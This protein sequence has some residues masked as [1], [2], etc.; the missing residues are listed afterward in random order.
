MISLRSRRKLKPSDAR[1]F[2]GYG[3]DLFGELAAA[4][5][6][7]GVIPQKELHECWQMGEVVHAEFPESL[8]IADIA[9]GHGLLAWILVLLARVSAAPIPRT[10]IALDVRRPP[11]ANVLSAAM[12]QRWPALEDSVH[13]VEGRVESVISTQ[14]STTLFVAAHACGSLSDRVLLAAIA[15]RNPLAVMPCCLSVRKQADSLST[16][17]AVAGLPSFASS[18]TTGIDPFR[19]AALNAVNYETCDAYIQSEVTAYNRIII[20]RPSSSFP[21][22]NVPAR[23]IARPIDV[24]SA[25]EARN[26][27]TRPSREWRRTFDVSC[28]VPNA[29]TGEEWLAGLASALAA[30]A[31]QTRTIAIADR[32]T[33]PASRRLAFTYRIAIESTSVEITK[34]EA[35]TLHRGVCLELERRGAILRR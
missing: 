23:A 18:S 6:S 8:R 29:A 15:S 27:S 21:A 28:W 5:C 16:L 24:D 19:V 4:V 22:I 11:S 2:K 35:L 9:A 17:A 34:T 26:L 14:G 3:S 20:G 30:P 32:Y 13:Y 25:S 33:E 12:I 7:T 31:T 10:A 1:H